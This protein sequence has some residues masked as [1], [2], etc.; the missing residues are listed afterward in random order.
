MAGR[1]KGTCQ[2]TGPRSFCR[3]GEATAK[4]LPPVQRQEETV[5]TP[6]TIFLCQTKFCQKT[7]D[8]GFWKIGSCMAQSS[9]L[10]E[11]WAEERQGIEPTCLSSQKPIG[12]TIVYRM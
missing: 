6:Y 4:T 8:I 11:S 7:A 5:Q 10:I 1:T 3:K 12:I 2:A 9:S